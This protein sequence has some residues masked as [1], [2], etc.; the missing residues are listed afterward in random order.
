MTMQ[1][2]TTAALVLS[3]LSLSAALAGAQDTAP[4]QPQ[5]QSRMQVTQLKSGW[6]GAPDVKFSRVDDQAA[7]F[8]GGYGGWV[9]DGTLLVGGGGYWLA[10]GSDDFEMGYGGLV[11]EWLARTNRRIGFGGRALIGAGTATLGLSYAD[12]V[13]TVPVPVEHAPI[14]FAHRGQGRL[15]GRIPPGNPTTRRY[16]VSESF[17]VAEPQANILVNL[18]SWMRIN[19][20]VGYRITGGTSLLEGRLNDVAATVAVQF[21]GGQ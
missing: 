15:P 12:L 14:R 6:L 7:T 9:T 19:A 5:G 10:N 4:E 17:F 11:V 1:K 13:G 8:A 2:T 21:G 16:L 3:A 20:G 18:T